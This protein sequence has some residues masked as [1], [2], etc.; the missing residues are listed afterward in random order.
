[1][2]NPPI[3]IRITCLF[4]TQS[5]TMD[6]GTKRQ[7]TNC[8]CW[9]EDD[10]FIGKKGGVVKR[11]LKCR[12]KD[13]KQK[14]KESV[15]ETRN[16]RQREKQYYV[17]YREKKRAEDEE[18]FL[19]HNAEI[20]RNWRQT[21]KE[22]L[23]AWNRNNVRYRITTI[24]QQARVKGIPWDETMTSDICGSMVV[25]SC[26]YCGAAPNDTTHGI[27]RMDNF[28]GYTTSNCVSCCKN[29]NFIKKALD[30]HTFLKRCRHISMLHGG[31]GEECKQ[32]WS[33]STGGSYTSYRSRAKNKDLEFAL[34]EDEFFHLKQL[35]CGYCQKENTFRHSNGIDRKDNTI[36]YTPTNSITCCGECNKMKGPLGHDTFIQHCKQ[37][38]E[39]CTRV[40]INIPEMET[41]TRVTMKRIMGD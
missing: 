41:C 22:H 25:A 14:K 16:A 24:K 23:A 19:A 36:G 39:Y 40:T 12:E 21:N 27:D 17:A 3:D 10:S 38:A 15:R 13:D 26:F 30:A 28:K 9:R 20:A 5:N 37:V 4:S 2:Q 32:A 29:C 18:A 8:M 11:C 31:V 33:D 34:T 6:H 7:C 35:P 1:M